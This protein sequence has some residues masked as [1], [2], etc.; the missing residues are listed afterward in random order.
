MSGHKSTGPG[1]PRVWVLQALRRRC[2][3]GA[4]GELAIL[5]VCG[6]LVAVLAAAA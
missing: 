1:F 4:A 5:S 6:L 2:G 3:R